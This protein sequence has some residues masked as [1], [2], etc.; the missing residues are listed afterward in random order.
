MGWTA[1]QKGPFLTLATAAM[2]IQALACAPMP[3]DVM[4]GLCDGGPEPVASI[5]MQPAE[6]TLRVGETAQLTATLV[7][8]DGG[9]FML[10][11]PQTFWVSANAG[12]A[13]VLGGGVRAVRVGKTY[14]SARAG[15]KADSALVTVTPEQ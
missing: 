1:T 7:A 12:I 6:L 10:C 2:A 15:G 11:A 5:R 14:I 13:S 4:G 9:T 8:P 3:S